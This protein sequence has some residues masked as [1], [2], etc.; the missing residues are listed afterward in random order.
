VNTVPPELGRLEYWLLD[1][2]VDWNIQLGWVGASNHAE[3]FNCRGHESSHAELVTVL[4]QLYSAGLIDAHRVGQVCPYDCDPVLLDAETCT[5]ALQESRWMEDARF[6][7]HYQLTDSGGRAW[8]NAASPRW[9]EM[10]TESTD[11]ERKVCR[12][13]AATLAQ[14]QK[15]IDA[16]SREQLVQV[17]E[18]TVT[19]LRPWQANYWKRLPQG[20]RVEF[21]RDVDSEDGSMDWPPS[22]S[23][24][25]QGTPHWYTRPWK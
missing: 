18:C 1:R 3:I 15:Y 6:F 20:V 4:V 19:K 14:A 12:I 17:G 21:H 22:R 2:V 24:F 9:N 16:L 8:E 23:E 10:V 25:F 7:T 5:A 13:E 11:M